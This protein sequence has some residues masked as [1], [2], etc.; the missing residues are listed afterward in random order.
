MEVALTPEAQSNQ[1]HADMADRYF[2]EAKNARGS[3]AW[4]F[5]KGIYHKLYSDPHWFGE[6]NT[7]TGIAPT[8]FGPGKLI[9]GASKAAKIAA[10]TAKE[11]KVLGVTRK[12]KDM[13]KNNRGFDSG[14]ARHVNSGYT[15]LARAKKELAKEQITN[16]KVSPEYANKWRKLQVKIAKSTD[17]GVLKRLY[18]EE[19]MLRQEYVDK[20]GLY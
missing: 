9:K 2:Q 4:Q 17:E 15:R 7:I 8:D 16:G 12:V 5:V 18:R 11:D 6:T 20:F 19:N 14:D 3:G 1:Y 10:Q 13:V